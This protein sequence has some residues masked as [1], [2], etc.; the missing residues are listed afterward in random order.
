MRLWEV[1]L[2]QG[3]SSHR[4]GISV[5]WVLMWHSV[6]WAKQTLEYVKEGKPWP[7]RWEIMTVY[8]LV[9]LFIHHKAW[10]CD[11]KGNMA[12]C[13]WV[14]SN[15]IQAEFVCT[16][17][18]CCPLVD[19]Q[20]FKPIKYNENSGQ[21]FACLYMPQHAVVN[22]HLPP[23]TAIQKNPFILIKCFFKQSNML[24]YYDR[25]TSG[26]CFRKALKDVKLDVCAHKP[27]F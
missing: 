15:E 25:Y 2:E 12:V 6:S 22:R 23:L 19:T 11:C 10:T 7:I 1:P 16:V 26:H 21:G 18:K 3:S 5:H 8:K 24:Q 14:H 4:V 17:S 9:P 27:H 20:S 13:V